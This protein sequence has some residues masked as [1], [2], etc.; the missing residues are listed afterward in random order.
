MVIYLISCPGKFFED[1]DD[2]GNPII[3]KCESKEFHECQINP[4]ENST[5]L[6][7]SS[8]FISTIHKQKQDL[9]EKLI[10]PN[11]GH[12]YIPVTKRK[13]ESILKDSLCNPS[14]KRQKHERE[15]SIEKRK[16]N[17]MS[18]R[19][20]D[21]QFSLKRFANHREQKN[22]NNDRNT[23][24]KDEQKVGPSHSRLTSDDAAKIEEKLENSKRK[25]HQGY[26]AHERAIVV[27]IW[28]A[29]LKFQ[30]LEAKAVDSQLKPW[31]TQDPAKVPEIHSHVVLQL[32]HW[33]LLHHE[34]FAT[35]IVV[36]LPLQRWRFLHPKGLSTA[37]VVD[38][39]LQL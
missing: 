20:S 15:E 38:L 31:S 29:I 2:N 22:S 13:Q 25:L 5:E 21:T 16:N 23:V 3:H 26:Q 24:K 28:I 33:D 10:G 11:E 1:I 27:K 35:A 7:G 36:D 18:Y 9:I 6:T 37:I 12:I 4:S 34:G 19:P 14:K 8:V 17:K 39:Q 30:R 32:Q